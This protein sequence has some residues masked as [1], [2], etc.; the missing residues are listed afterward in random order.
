M[1]RKKRKYS[2]KIFFTKF[3]FA[4]AAGASLGVIIPMLIF[5]FASNKGYITMAN[6]NELQAK[7]L[8]VFYQ[9]KMISKSWKSRQE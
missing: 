2:L 6:Y 9:Q 7:K 8:L 4:L 1:K 5:A 3:I